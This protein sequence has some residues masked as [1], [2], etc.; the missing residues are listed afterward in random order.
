MCSDTVVEIL[1]RKYRFVYCLDVSPSAGTVVS[2]FIKSSG[3]LVSQNKIILQDV[4]TGMVTIDAMFGA[5]MN[6]MEGLVKPVRLGS[7]SR[8]LFE[9]Y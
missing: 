5:L 6:H 1:S 8:D 2:T 4:Q 9:F 7:Y 3:R